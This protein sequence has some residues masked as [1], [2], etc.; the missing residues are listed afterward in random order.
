MR[1]TT[2]NLAFIARISLAKSAKFDVSSYPVDIPNAC[3]IVASKGYNVG[4]AKTLKDMFIRYLRAAL[5]VS[6]LL[7]LIPVAAFALTN[8]TT[9]ARSNENG[10]KN[11][12]GGVPTRITWEA[13][14]DKGESVTAV[15]LQF[16]QGSEFNDATSARIT[17]L[18]GTKRVEVDYNAV[19]SGVDNT[20]AVNFGTPLEEGQRLRIEI[21][22]AALPNV[23]GMVALSGS[24][25]RDDGEVVELDEGPA[26][27][28]TSA[29]AAQKMAN[30]LGEQPWV[31]AWNSVPVLRLF[32]NPQ[33]AVTSIPTLVVGWL[34]SL[35]LV[36]FGFPLA[37]PIGLAFAFMKISKSRI[38][39]VIAALYTGVVRGTPLFLQ[40]YIAFFG[41]PL[42][43]IKLNDYVLAVLVLAF[44]SGAY[45]C[46][47]FRAGIQS[48][49]KGQFEA[50]RSLG[51]NAIQTMFSVIIPQ[52]IRRVIPTM[53][54]EFILLYKDTSLL[55]A[56]GVMELMLYARSV[57][58]NT[59]NMT[60]Y[61][62]AALFYLVV[63]LPLIRVVTILEKRLAASDEGGEVKKRKNRR[64]AFEQMAE[65]LAETAGEGAGDYAQLAGSVDSSYVST[66]KGD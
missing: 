61:I 33:L 20:V 27:Q 39:H 30:W 23:E 47:I 25:T 44:N 19:V 9:T 11:V 41:L 42:M 2:R 65:E 37:I 34:L 62:V 38:L 16:P 22:D 21:Y 26:I 4:M 18:D 56:V 28:V 55:A 29:S 8:D 50:S 54:S 5:V 14:V 58:A 10:T 49:P 64:G 60:P 48:I 51:M 57:V 66:G 24:Y 36:L 13:A 35:M 31:Q 3:S 1:S 32:L 17:V 40:I 59:G 52:T 7:Y 43:G 46:E 6:L 45:M 63:T 15:T 53:T 12:L